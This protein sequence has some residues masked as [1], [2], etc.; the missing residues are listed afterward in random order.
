MN[1]AASTQENITLIEKYDACV[2]I[3]KESGE[4]GGVIDKIQAANEKNIAVVMIQR[5]E[6]DNLNKND[7]ISDLDE[8][9]IK[10]K[11]F[12]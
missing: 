1:G 8:L 5:P 7:V 12:F 11:N 9:D 10:L 4:I 2:M 3:T 6:I